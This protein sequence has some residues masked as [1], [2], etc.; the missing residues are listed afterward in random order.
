M[1]DPVSGSCYD[2]PEGSSS[3]TFTLRIDGALFPVYCDLDTDGGGWTLVG[4][5]ASATAFD[6][7]S[8][9]DGT[10]GY[11]DDLATLQPSGSQDCVWGGL[12]ALYPALATSASPAR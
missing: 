3:G 8:C 6:D 9:G 4:S 5:T 2:L 7:H 10:A 11:Y 1:S 12:N